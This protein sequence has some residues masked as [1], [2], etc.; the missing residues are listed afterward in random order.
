MRC[1]ALA[2][3]AWAKAEAAGFTEDDH[4]PKS[5]LF[6]SPAGPLR[7]HVEALAR[8]GHVHPTLRFHLCRLKLTPTAER[9]IEQPHAIF[10]LKVGKRTVVGPYVS[11][12][13]R[14]PQTFDRLERDPCFLRRLEVAYAT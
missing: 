14:M 13:A 12:A 9:T 6:L 8:T 2:L 3:E 1:A 4:H 7:T 10:N 11:L 5:V